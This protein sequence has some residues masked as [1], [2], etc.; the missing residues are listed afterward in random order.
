MSF[1]L[2]SRIALLFLALIGAG[3]VFFVL[4]AR[5]VD[6]EAPPPAAPRAGLGFAYVDV[7]SE[8]GY[9]MRNRTGKEA[10]KQLIVEAMP[11]GIAVADFNRDGTMDLYCPNGTD[12]QS[13]DAKRDRFRF[14]PPDLAPRNALYWNL[15]G[16]RFVNGAKEAGVDDPAWSFGT[17]AGDLDND[18]WPD[19]FLCNW[20]PNR[21]YRNRGD[22]TFTEIAVQAGVAGDPRAWSCGACLVDYDRD[23]DLD[24]YVAQYADLYELVRN[25]EYSIVG[26]DGRIEA[27]TCRWRGIPVYCGPLG[28]RPHNDRLYKNLV[29]ETGELRFEDVT[30]Q[31]GVFIPESPRM[32]T[33]S[34]E[35]PYYGFQ[36]VAWDINGDGWQDI[37]VAN[38][39]V[40]NL[41]WMNRGG[42]RFVDEAL[43]LNLAMS[44]TDYVAQ[45]S[46]G[47][48]VADVSRDGRMDVSITEFSHDH[49]NLLVCREIGA[50]EVVFDERAL[51]S[52]LREITFFKLG[53]GA[54][55][56]DPDLDGDLDLFFACGHVYPEVD[57]HPAQQTSYRQ[58]NMLILNEDPV[59]LR[60][61]DVTADAGPGL[62]L[63]K[64]SRSA[65]RV[66]F[67]ND[68]DL[69]VATTELNDSPALLRCDVD[70]KR[71]WIMFHLRGEP[72]ARVPRDPAGAVVRVTTGE[73][74]QSQVLHFG[75]SFLSSEDPRLHFG[76]GSRARADRVE[77]LWPDGKRQTLHDVAG[78]RLHVIEYAP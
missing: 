25:P 36:P 2:Q 30:K 59:Q 73:V 74:T 20:G 50:G 56:Y 51:R 72:S 63:Q 48:A 15:D 76:L 41:A 28:L 19:I 62:Q 31:A 17:V 10:Q 33:E 60:F 61:R 38:D 45:A 53:W 1:P 58:R 42:K 13:Y 64:A 7:A 43:Q 52:G 39:S 4:A 29:R 21:L 78:D 71:H 5:G 32:R 75:S 49:F 3:A 65:V 55:L 8:L 23:G 14:L 68:G 6:G 34:S 26:P 37:F 66:D 54:L 35:G 11:P 24:L 16:R 44:Q 18:D 47:V 69:D 57:R 12:I 27:R 67:D 77:I 46:M 22:G 70:P 40:S 9:R